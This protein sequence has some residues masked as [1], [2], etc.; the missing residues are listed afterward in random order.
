MKH[1]QVRQSNTHIRSDRDGAN[2]AI[3][4]Y[5]ETGRNPTLRRLSYMRIERLYILVLTLLQYMWVSRITPT[6]Y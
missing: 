6:I 3:D 4:L 2:I 1:V 5:L